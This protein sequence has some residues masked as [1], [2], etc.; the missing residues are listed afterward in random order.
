MKGFALPGRERSSARGARD[1]ARFEALF[2]RHY[3]RVHGILRHLLGSDEEAED[4]AQEVFL[5]LY[6]QKTLS[7]DE[8]GQGRWLARV[9][10]NVGLNAL[11]S[12]KRQA[13]RLERNALLSQTE[14]TERTARDDP[15][16]LALAREEAAL[17]EQALG[18]M[19]DRARACL[20]LR[21]G[22]LSY[23][24]IAEA[25]DVAP[26]S[27][28]TI[29]ARAERDFRRQYLALTNGEGS[30]MVAGRW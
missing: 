25:I 13:A 27:V 18:G 20:L 19:A 2:L 14:G 7:A 30:R 22:G 23:A 28:G 6:R 24:E 15:S 3:R 26:G 5:R 10:T 29:L 12:S 9:A 4:A 21:S 8:V 1:D 17:V 16:A 11:R